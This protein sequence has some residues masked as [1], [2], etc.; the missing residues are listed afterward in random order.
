[1]PRIEL[2]VERRDLRAAHGL[3]EVRAR[4]IPRPSTVA[5]VKATSVTQSVVTHRPRGPGRSGYRSGRPAIAQSG[6]TPIRRD[7]EQPERKS[8]RRRRLLCVSWREARG[9]PTA[10]ARPAML[11]R[12]AVFVEPLAVEAIDVPSGLHRGEG[13]VE[14][15]RRDRSPAWRMKPNSSEPD[16]LAHGLEDAR[17]GADVAGD[18]GLIHQH[19]VDVAGS[20]APAPTRRTCRT[21]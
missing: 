6:T 17:I 12:G 10:P 2:G 15:A 16:R 9:S 1:M 21:A 5:S 4:A 11:L 20:S 13:R 19:H 7:G 14:R 8:A 3:P 18:R